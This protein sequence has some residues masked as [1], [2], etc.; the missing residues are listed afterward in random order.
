[1]S[2]AIQEP[3][4]ENWGDMTP[5]QKGAFCKTCSIDVVD[6][7]NKS[8]EEIRDTLKANMGQ[9][10]CGRFEVKQLDKL[11]HDFHIWKNQPARTFQSKFLWA[12]LIAFGMTLFTACGTSTA[13]ELNTDFMTTSMIHE[14]ISDS[15]KTDTTVSTLDSL[16]IEPDY[17]DFIMGDIAYDPSWE[18]GIIEN[19]A[20]DSATTCQEVQPI[21]SVKTPEVIEYDPRM[22]KGKISFPEDYHESLEEDTEKTHEPNKIEVI[23]NIETPQLSASV[24]PN[25]TEN[26]ATLIMSPIESDHYRIALY[27]IDGN[28]IY[29]IHSGVFRAGEQLFPIDLTKQTPGVYLVTFTSNTINQSLKINKVD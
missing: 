11:K 8:A 27:A 29:T 24:F 10:M 15:I 4:Q 19:E 13:Q 28:L 2:I 1:M 20:N 22:V 26:S 14:T 17:T 16:I 7:S 3:C 6:F 23:K 21:D 5:S 25:P 9:S 12:C 18:E